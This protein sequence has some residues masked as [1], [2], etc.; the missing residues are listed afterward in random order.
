MLI[1][2]SWEA[3]AT[4]L[5]AALAS[6]EKVYNKWGFCLNWAPGKSEVM[7]I[8]TGPGCRAVKEHYRTQDGGLALSFQ[9]DNETVVDVQLVGHYKHVGIIISANGSSA[10]AFDDRV[11]L[12]SMAAIKISK[13]T[14]NP[15]LSVDTRLLLV[16]SLVTSRLTYGLEVLTLNA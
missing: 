15:T 12:A 13:V 5:P 2:N 8:F 10:R 14:R 11:R 9:R 6:V 4:S 1:F 7:V 3:M 16:S